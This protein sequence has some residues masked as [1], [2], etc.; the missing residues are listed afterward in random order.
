MIFEKHSRY[1]HKN[2]V[3]FIGFCSIAS[4]TGNSAADGNERDFDWVA[5]ITWLLNT[6]EFLRVCFGTE[7]NE[8][9]KK[10]KMNGSEDGQFDD[11]EDDR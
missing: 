5:K 8:L 6:C 3:N 10:L 9:R 1:V 4:R 7:T 11:A 2:S